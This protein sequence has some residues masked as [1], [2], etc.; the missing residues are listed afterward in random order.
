MAKEEFR[1]LPDEYTNAGYTYKLHKRGNKGVIYLAESKN[2]HGI[3]FIAE[4]FVIKIAKAMNAMV[5]NTLIIAPK[6][7][8]IPGNSDFGAWAWCISSGVKEQII[9]E[10]EKIFQEIE[11][12]IL[13]EPVKTV[14]DEESLVDTTK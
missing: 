14:K 4:V 8:R 5:K 2:D 3:S 1:S 13:P 7:E 9:E 11:D 12:G 10:A 6:R